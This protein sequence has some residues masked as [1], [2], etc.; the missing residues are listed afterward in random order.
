MCSALLIVANGGSTLLQAIACGNACVAVPIATD[1]AERIRRCVAA[2][3][4]VAAGLARGA[5]GTRRLFGTRRRRRSRD[6]GPGSSSRAGAGP[7]GALKF[8]ASHADRRF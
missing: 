3:V 8:A 1:Q 7:D 2:G 5:C 6:A 4:A